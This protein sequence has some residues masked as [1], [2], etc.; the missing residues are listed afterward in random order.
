[1]KKTKFGMITL[2]AALV[3][4][5]CGQSNGGGTG[6]TDTQESSTEAAGFDIN[7]LQLAV[8][9]NDEV[10]DGGVLDV[11]VVTD[12]QFQGLFQWE[13]YQ[14]AYDRDSCYQA[15]NICSYKTKISEL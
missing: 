8:E 15:M 6:S 9:N 13:F 14:D 1:M 10:I 7:D 11:A 12:T 2:L 3:L 4:G 5:A